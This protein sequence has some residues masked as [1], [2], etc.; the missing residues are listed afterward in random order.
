MQRGLLI[1]AFYLSVVNVSGSMMEHLVAAHSVNKSDY[2]L[3]NR[4]KEKL[5]R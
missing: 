1:L 4:S 3:S 5:D 2:K